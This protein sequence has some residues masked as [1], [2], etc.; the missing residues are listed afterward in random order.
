VEIGHR[1]GLAAEIRNG[2]AQGATVITHPADL[3]ED[4]VRVRSR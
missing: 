2:V 3:I 1:S 4:G